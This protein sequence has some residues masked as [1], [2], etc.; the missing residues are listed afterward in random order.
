MRTSTSPAFTD[1]LSSTSTASTLPGIL[2]AIAVMCASTCASSLDTR[3][4]KWKYAQV[5]ADTASSSM[6]SRMNLTGER[7]GSSSGGSAESGRGGFDNSSITSG[8][9][10]ITFPHLDVASRVPDPSGSPTRS[11]GSIFHQPSAAAT[12]RPCRYFGTEKTLAA[13]VGQPILAAAGFP[14]GAWTRW[15]ARPQAGLP[16]PQLLAPYAT[17]LTPLLVLIAWQLFTR[18]TT[19]TMPAG[20]LAEYFSTYAFQAIQHKLQNALMLFIHSWWIVFPALVPATAALA[21]RNRRDPATLFLLAWIGIFFAGALAIFFSGS[22]RYLLPMAAPVAILASRLPTKWL[23][24]A[25]AIQLAIA[26]ALA[27]VN[28][29]HWDGYRAFAASLRA[30][31]A[32]HRVWVDNDW[33]LRYRSEE[34]RV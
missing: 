23:A 24:P 18:L 28:Y 13:D 32:G 7:R 31:S 6:P 15:K 3:S 33:G 25:F 1:W 27:T 14:A 8:I 16:A 26:L 20:K 17:L 29:Q 10:I 21:W 22:A 9:L 2:G 34:R 12:T 19:G 30:P 5:P 4:R 11:C